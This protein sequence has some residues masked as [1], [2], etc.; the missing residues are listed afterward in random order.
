[1]KH[2]VHDLLN[3]INPTPLERVALQCFMLVSTMP[4]YEEYGPEDLWDK[5]LVEFAETKQLMAMEGVPEDK[6]GELDPIEANREQKIDNLLMLKP[7][8][9]HKN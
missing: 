5:M 9:K 2:P 6:V 4:G 7:A 1:L 3:K 8:S